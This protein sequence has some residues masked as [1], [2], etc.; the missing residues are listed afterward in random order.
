MP[1]SYSD[2]HTEHTNRNAGRG[3]PYIVY[4]AGHTAI[5]L[6]LLE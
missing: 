2:E 4:Q 6:S 1:Q 3:S 5:R